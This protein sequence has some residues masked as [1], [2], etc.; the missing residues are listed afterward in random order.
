MGYIAPGVILIAMGAA[1]IGIVETGE[2]FTDLAL[3]ALSVVGIATGAI[4]VG[5]GCH[6]MGF[7]SGVIAG[8]RTQ[9]GE[10]P[11]VPEPTE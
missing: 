9:Q 6:E 3:N 2:A 1:A 10:Q 11:T 5:L 4:A 8:L 7:D